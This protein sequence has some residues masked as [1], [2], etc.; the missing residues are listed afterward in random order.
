T[1]MSLVRALRVSSVLAW[2]MPLT[3]RP[4]L[5]GDGIFVSSLI[6]GVMALGGVESWLRSK[7]ILGGVIMGVLVALIGAGGWLWIS[8][9]LPHPEVPLAS[10]LPGALVVWAG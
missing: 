7:R 5:L 4:H 1:G 8:P 2:R 3:R 6:I 10:L 9:R